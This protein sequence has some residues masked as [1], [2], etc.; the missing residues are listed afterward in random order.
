MV[1]ISANIEAELIELSPEEG[2]E[3]L[4]SIGVAGSGVS[5]LIRSVYHLLGLRTYL[6]TGEKE[7]RAMDNNRRNEGPT[8]GRS[9]SHG[10]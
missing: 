10:F 3:F 5:D 9:D 1:V 7:T 8:G 2:I 4:E 6:T